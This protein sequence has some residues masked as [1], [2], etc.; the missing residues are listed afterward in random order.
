M[1]ATFGFC[2]TASSARAPAGQSLGAAVGR[3]PGVI[4]DDRRRRKIGGKLSRRVEMPPRRLQIVGHSEPLKQR[5]ALAPSGIVHRARRAAFDIAHAHCRRR[6]VADAAHQ[7]ALGV[8]GQHLRD[9][10]TT[11]LGMT[12]AGARQAIVAG[13]RL[14]PA[15]FRHRIGA[16]PFGFHVHGLGDAEAGAVATVIVRQVVALERRIIA[17]AKWDRDRIA[18]PG[19]IIAVEVPEVLVGID[20]GNG[21]L[22]RQF[23][24]WLRL[25]RQRLTPSRHRY[26]TALQ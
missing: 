6:L 20:N 2:A 11:R 14:D 25:G 1:I 26:P 7:R 8:P 3:Q 10:G 16:I 17:V 15:R 4:D 12:D 22:V 9:I 24:L 13:H 23:R 5:V 19:I 18:E 21:G